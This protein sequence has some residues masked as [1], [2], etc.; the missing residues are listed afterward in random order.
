MSKPK[1]PTP[2]L[3]FLAV[4]EKE[5]GF[6]QSCLKGDFE[7]DLGMVLKVGPTFNFSL[8]TSYYE[9]EMGSPLWKSFYAFEKLRGPEF[10]IDLKHLCYALER[11]TS[12]PEGKRV[13]NLDPGYLNLSKVILSTFKDYSH[14]IYLGRCVFGE[15]TLI[16]RDKTFQSLPWTYPDYQESEVIDFFNEVRNLYK[17]RAHAR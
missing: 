5:R 6:F 4:T 17:E 9:K 3:Y 1:E 14:R 15:V 12:T 13:V 16:Y 11:K 2:V 10:L 8:F 7:E